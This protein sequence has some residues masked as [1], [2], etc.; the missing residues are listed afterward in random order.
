MKTILTYLIDPADAGKTV[1]GYLSGSGYSD[2]LIVRLRNTPGSFLIG[3]CPVFS[4]R[5][6]NENDRLTV[7]LTEKKDR[8]P[9][10]RFPWISPSSLRMSI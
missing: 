9:S 1:A 4:N 5:I 2:R 8:T 3:D 6:L 10:F 7:I